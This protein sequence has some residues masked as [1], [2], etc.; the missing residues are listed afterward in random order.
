MPSYNLTQNELRVIVT[1]L[2]EPVGYLDFAIRTSDGQTSREALVS[3]SGL[4]VTQWIRDNP[5]QDPVISNEVGMVWW[6]RVN[7]QVNIPTP[8]LPV[9]KDSWAAILQGWDASILSG[10]ARASVISRNSK[11]S[12]MVDEN[13]DADGTIPSGTHLVHQQQI[14][15]KVLTVLT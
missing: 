13:G 7:D 12:N 6:I 1:W 4:N 9:E 8:Q 3:D 5:Q 11:S 10:L 15:S 14:I 2:F